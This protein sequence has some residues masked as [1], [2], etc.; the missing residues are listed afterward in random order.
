M[1]CHRGNNAK[2]IILQIHELPFDYFIYFPL[3]NQPN[4]Y[5][6]YI[7]VHIIGKKWHILGYIS[8]KK[9]SL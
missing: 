8:W 7:Y 4:C 5:I 2:D 3:S 9:D 1:Q 6:Y